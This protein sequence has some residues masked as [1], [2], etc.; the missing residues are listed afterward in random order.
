MNVLSKL[1]RIVPTA[2]LAIGLGVPIYALPAT[3]SL[4][5][6]R[7]PG[8]DKLTLAQAAAELSASGEAGWDLVEAARALVAG[9]MR[10]CRRNSFDSAAVAFARGY[11]YCVQHAYALADLLTQL[12]FEAKVVQAFRNQFLDGEVNSHAW[13]S[14]TVDGEAR[15]VDSLFYD[16]HARQITFAPLSRVTGVA[17]LFKAFTWW[18]ATAV[19]AHRFYLS[20]KDE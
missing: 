12:G 1:A 5:R 15:H 11:G 10:Y 3:L 18:G 17:P 13:V 19:N 16:A 8:V 14:V 7:R 2:L 6:G 20:G 9:R 4:P